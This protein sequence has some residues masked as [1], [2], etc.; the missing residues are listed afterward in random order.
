MIS[1]PTV[2][3]YG[4]STMVMFFIFITMDRTPL[5]AII[6]SVCIIANYYIGSHGI[7][8]SS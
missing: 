7:W 6:L 8:K 4:G 3:I 2:K 5:E 1:F